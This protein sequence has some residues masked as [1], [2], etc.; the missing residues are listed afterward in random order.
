MAAGA[1]PFE[2]VHR[3]DIYPQNLLP[4][5]G[6]IWTSMFLHGGWMHLIGNMWF[7]WVFGDNVEEA[8]GVDPLTCS[9]I[10][11][12]GRSARSPSATACPT[13]LRR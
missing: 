7:L 10:S 2:I 9:S 4:V 11:W 6:S 1:I 5:P 13:R 3:V 8:M 12:S